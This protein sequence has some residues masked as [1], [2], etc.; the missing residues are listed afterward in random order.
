MARPP[1][2]AVPEEHP[3]QSEHD[4]TLARLEEL[5]LN[6]ANSWHIER[7]EAHLAALADVISA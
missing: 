1:I 4:A 6:P 5:R 2:R 3:M 7:A